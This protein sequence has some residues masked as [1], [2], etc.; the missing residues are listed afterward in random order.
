MTQQQQM[1]PTYA[2]PNLYIDV[3]VNGQKQVYE[4]AVAREIHAQLGQALAALDA[5]QVDLETDPPNPQ[6]EP[7]TQ[8]EAE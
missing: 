1:P 4:V 5:P 7:E 2:R 6:D 3:V 8:D